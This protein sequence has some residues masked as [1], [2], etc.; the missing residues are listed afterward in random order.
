MLIW[1]STGTD[2]EERFF[3]NKLATVNP[4][5]PAPKIK[6]RFPSDDK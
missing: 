1:C 2:D 3:R 6:I 5:N 4:P